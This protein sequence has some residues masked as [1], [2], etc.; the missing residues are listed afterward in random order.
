[1]RGFFVTALVGGTLL[2]ANAFANVSLKNGNFFI[3]Y[4][5]LTHSGG[6]EPKVERVYNSKSSHDG[7]F[8]FGWG[9]D[10][11]VYLKISADG[12]VVV[13]EN[14]GGAQNR[15]TPPT[16]NASEVDK[17]VDE[18]M[19][20]KLKGGGMSGELAATEKTRIR[21]DARYRND[22]WERLYDKGL[23]KARQ[24][25]VGAT[26]KS[27]KFSFQTVTKAADGY[28]R[29]F[30]NG[31]V[32]TFD[33]Q[34]HLTR[35]A[36]K[37]GN[38]MNLAYDKAGHLATIQDSLNRRMTFT[39][40]RF[41][42]V[43]KVVGENGKV[44]TYKYSGNELIYSKDADGNVYEYKYSQNGRHNLVEIKYTDGTTMQIGFN[45][46]NQNETV[47]WVKDRDGSLT[48]YGYIGDG[49][50]G[51]N[52]GTSVAT[53]GPDGKEISK[54]KYEYWEKAK[55]DGERYTYKLAS[56]V[57][58]DKTETI[59]NECCGLPL[60]I[61]R[62]GEKTTFEYD[63]KGHVTKKITPTE[64]TQL[65]YDVKSSKVSKV[66]KAP[67]TGK[68]KPQWAQYAYDDKGNLVQAVNSEGKK[69]K[70]V[71]DH[72]GRIK[73]LVDQ[74]KR[75]LQFTYN[76][77]SRPVEI[78]DPQVGKIQVQYTNSGDIKKVDS[79]GGRK[80]ALQVTSAFQN[81]LDIIRP[82]GVTLSF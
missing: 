49:P 77:A 57:D 9:S 35:M 25:T 22:E 73:A 24:V 52:F 75:Q 67:K 46:V 48:E 44:C 70:I 31:Q 34:G 17:A 54:S 2:A 32:Q 6:I 45:P 68:A 21:N 13:H 3:G 37:N 28:V 10:Y 7:I 79:S 58:G 19:A 80:I 76:E 38:F 15:F 18:I 43:E 62:N 39:F 60:E 71:Y 78:A 30:D 27:N 40:N 20:A 53:K 82:A 74:D 55:L 5:D 69:V 26:L 65:E 12:S 64:V 61:T 14:G 11:E 59:Y 47:K 8:G 4:T 56:D 50:G 42:K 16:I 81:L 63:A 1:M 51:M 72:Q 66:V 29:K 23:V 41:G 33:N 36:D